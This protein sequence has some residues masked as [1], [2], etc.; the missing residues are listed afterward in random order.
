M[1]PVLPI[2]RVGDVDEAIELAKHVERGCRHTASMYSTQHGQ[3]HAM[4]RA[5]NCSIFVKNGPNYAGLGVGGEGFATVSI[6]SPPGRDD[7][8]PLFSRE[9]RVTVVGA[10]RIV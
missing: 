2:V 7:A 5:I 1:M 9:R 3:A 6:A 8:A 10:L 4:A